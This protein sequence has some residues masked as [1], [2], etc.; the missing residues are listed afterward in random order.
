MQPNHHNPAPRP[1]NS[2]E[3]H[4]ASTP[5]RSSAAKPATPTSSTT[6]VPSAVSVPFVSSAA[7]ANTPTTTTANPT[8]TD[9]PTIKLINRAL[10]LILES[11]LP[12]ADIAEDL[13]LTLTSLA[14]LLDHPRATSALRALEHLSQLRDKH[15]A[16]T[17]RETAL[18]RLAN[19]SQ[20]SDNESE[21]RRASSTLLRELREPRDASHAPAARD[22][23]ETL[24][25]PRSP[26]TESSSTKDPRW[27]GAAALV[28]RNPRSKTNARGDQQIRPPSHSPASAAASTAYPFPT[29]PRSS[30]SGAASSAHKPSGAAL[31]PPRFR[32]TEALSGWP[33]SAEPG[34]R[35]TSTG[36]ETRATSESIRQTEP[37]HSKRSSES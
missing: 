22:A 35:S 9:Q 31:P 12:L 23:R 19:I 37:G 29:P 36:L 34:V 21:A 30:P 27:L 11:D 26:H 20:Y 24:G 13:N 7:S 8:P 4:H 15:R 5:A 2:A 6:S 17:R 18:A 25:S 10:Q 32:L 14:E 28:L 3:A 1:S 33:G 16:A